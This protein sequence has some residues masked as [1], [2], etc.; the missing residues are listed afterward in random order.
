MI[1]KTAFLFKRPY[2]VNNTVVDFDHYVPDTEYYHIFSPVAGWTTLVREWYAKEP[3]SK[4][5]AV[6]GGD[7]GTDPY[8]YAPTYSTSSPPY[9]YFSTGATSKSVGR[10][11]YGN[12]Y[13]SNYFFC[14]IVY[15][16]TWNNRPVISAQ[17]NNYCYLYT[18]NYVGILRTTDYSDN[19]TEVSNFPIDGGV[20]AG[21]EYNNL[22]C[23][24]FWC[25]GNLGT[26]NMTTDGSVIATA[27]TTAS[28][29]SFSPML[30][31]NNSDLHNPGLKVYELLMSD[32]IPTTARRQEV[33]GYLC[34]KY[35]LNLKMPNTH[36]YYAAPPPSL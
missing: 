16:T 30:A 15:R 19:I 32:N 13:S 27:S 33:E 26:I 17:L 6:P 34:H 1:N 23:T 11:G 18:S 29:S 20:P 10:L 25:D 8:E 9:I 14:A 3:S 22:L 31:S 2:L 28:L 21:Y 4:Y 5:L 36:P 7:V 12:G 35:G 24:C